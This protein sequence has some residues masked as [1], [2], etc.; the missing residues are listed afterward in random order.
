M[1]LSTPAL[2]PP[3]RALPP[4]I[5][6]PLNVPH[7]GYHWDGTDRRFFEG[8]Y[9]RVSIPELGQGFAF[10]YSIEDP[11]GGQEHSGGVA[12][13]LG[14]GDQHQWRSYPQV[15]G[16][17]ASSDR[18]ALGHWGKLKDPDQFQQPSY[19]DPNRFFH[20]VSSGYQATEHLNQGVFTDPVVGQEAR[21]LY[22]ID[23]VYTYGIPPR[24]TM[25]PFSY[26]PV[27]EP[28]WQILMAHG[29]ATGWVEWNGQ[30]YSFERAP[31]YS[32]KNWGG[33]FPSKW[34]WLNCNDFA[35]FT[36][37]A[38]TCAGARRG[39]LWWQDEV[40]MISL[41]WQGHFLEWM[42]E[43][44]QVR[45]QVDP[46]GSWQV[47]GERGDYFVRVWGST[48]RA[49]CPLLAPTL[50]GMQFTCRDTLLGRIQLEL[51]RKQGQLRILEFETQSRSGG[52]ET[53]GG[54][55]AETWNGSC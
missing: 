40:A 32:E 26:L 21:W 30:R 23:P 27:F 6:V 10:M 20:T 5:S 12:Q 19:L 50:G 22:R 47:E 49:G 13:I 17:W 11:I 33:A 45:W 28:G 3:D 15:H 31:A 18:L 53:G 42:P 14:P 8:W 51:W 55:W 38:L 7:G 48:D 2:D 54:P 24:P 36:D 16:F 29:L 39:V 41:H 4:G 37:L 44:S 9:Y 52:L 43:N 35:G 34:F 1:T 25:G 46:W